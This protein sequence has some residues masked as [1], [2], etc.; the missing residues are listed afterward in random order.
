MSA[1][2]AVTESDAFR[3]FVKHGPGKALVRS[4][5]FR[6]LALRRNAA[7]SMA[8]IRN[9]PDRFADVRT[10]CF[11]IGHNKSGTSM[12]GGLLDAHP[13]VILSDEVDALQYADASFSREQIFH[14]IE[15]GAEAEARK[16][17]ITARRLEPYSYAVPGQWQGRSDRP[18][19]VGDSTSGSS[20]RRLGEQPDLLTR[21]G[22]LMGDVDV[23]MIHVIRNPFDPISAMMVRG[24][25]G[26][27]NSIDHYFAACERLERIHATAAPEAIIAVRHEA[28]VA[29]PAAGLE[30]VCRFLGVGADDEYLDACAAIIRRVPDR[31]REMVG[32]P[33]MWIEAVER[34]ITVFDFLEGYRYAD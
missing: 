26:F 9:D 3:R 27:Q 17:R 2:Q 32:W 24:G 25:R 4:S 19:V 1:W 18:V 30:R 11:F 31:S 16:G 22:S 12:L 33:Q 14:V 20:T 6:S 8:A 7:R 34:R 10:F 5:A 15:R 28:F 29:D 21:L 13:Q 23:K